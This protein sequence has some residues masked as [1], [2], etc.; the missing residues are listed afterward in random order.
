LK[1]LGLSII[2]A[3]KGL[4]VP[5]EFVAVHVDDGGISNETHEI[6]SSVNSFGNIPILVR[7]FCE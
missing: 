4:N 7:R 3:S 6:T 1:S 2:M 5:L